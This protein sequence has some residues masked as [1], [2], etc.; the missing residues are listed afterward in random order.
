MLFMLT[1]HSV[2]IPAAVI[3]PIVSQIPLQ[4]LQHGCVITG[5]PPPEPLVQC[6][7]AAF[8]SS[9]LQQEP[10]YGLHN[11]TVFCLNITLNSRAL[12]LDVPSS[13]WAW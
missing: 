6:E 3:T 13:V 4:H 2:V 5:M 11:S 8:P 9:E 7:D 10:N 12:S 1:S